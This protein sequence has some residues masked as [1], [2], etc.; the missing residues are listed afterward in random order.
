[1][2]KNKMKK[3][4]EFSGWPDEEMPVAEV[5][6]AFNRAVAEGCMEIQLTKKE[7]WAFLQIH[8]QQI[9]PF[10]NLTKTSFKFWGIRIYIEA[11]K[12]STS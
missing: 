10:T 8:G 12:E 5:D 1:M 4:R 2:L 11:S 3:L 6:Y 7:F 9:S